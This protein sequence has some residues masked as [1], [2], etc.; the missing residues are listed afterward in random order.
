MDERVRNGRRARPVVVQIAQLVFAY[1]IG[2]DELR[3]EILDEAAPPA[4]PPLARPRQPARAFDRRHFEPCASELRRERTPD[5]GV[6]A[7][8]EVILDPAARVRV[9]AAHRRRARCALK[10]EI[11]HRREDA[12]GFQR[13]V[14]ALDRRVEIGDQE[15]EKE[16]AE[17]PV[18]SAD[19]DVVSR[20]IGFERHDVRKTAAQ[21]RLLNVT[22]IRR[23]L[24][25]CAHAAA[26]TD[27]AAEIERRKPGAASEIREVLSRAETRARP[28]RLRLF[29]PRC[30]LLAQP[31]ELS[32]VHANEIIRSHRR[33]IHINIRLL[34]ND[35]S[36]TGARLGA[37]LLAYMLGV[38]LIITLVPLQFRWPDGNRIVLTG[39]PLEVI[40]NVILFVPLGFFYRLAQPAARS[41]LHVLALGAL[42]SLAIEATQYFQPLRTPSP[43]DVATNAAGAWLGALAAERV[44]RAATV[45]GRLV[46]WLA[47]ELPLMGLVYLLVPLLWIDGLSSGGERARAVLSPLLAMF[48]ALLLGGMQRHYFGPARA[49]EP[50]R[51]AVFAALWFVAGAFP[52]LATRP[53]TVAGGAVFAGVVCWLRGVRTAGAPTPNRR[54]E[55]SL[56]R[57]AAPFYALYVALIVFLPL[58]HARGEWSVRAGFPD[59]MSHQIEILRLLELVAAFTL[60]G[61]IVAEFGG[62]A[63]ARYRDALPRLA[64]FALV[65][66]CALEVAWGFRAE[67]GASIAR[68]ALVAAAALYGGWLYYLQRAHVVRLLTGNAAQHERRD[69]K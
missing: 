3:T 41:T 69:G 32:R 11:F 30:V 36:D 13:A 7:V 45:G 63:V 35:P 28:Q 26:R 52:S 43:L 62:R 55:V 34:Q 51:T 6:A 64:T 17:S 18:V 61:Y 66:A 2:L 37:A 56:L 9:E 49:A 14:D 21:R 24:V 57:F 20:E 22:Q 42:V 48:G 68:G 12:A 25:D 44:A 47:L 29:A 31:L 60:V 23:S 16:A 67:H 50:H 39:E 53:A 15:S 59:A 27:D 54:F 58:R 46:G 1:A 40:A 5:S 19:P 10:G 65:L 8:L 38:T 4:P 33:H